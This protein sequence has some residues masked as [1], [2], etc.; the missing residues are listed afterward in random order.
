MSDI[1]SSLYY[2]YF[3][4]IVPCTI[5]TLLFWTGVRGFANP[6]ALADTFGLPNATKDEV[7][8]VQSSTGRNLAAALF[9]WALVYM[10]ERKALGV[11]LIC[12]TWAGIADTKLLIE[13]PRG[14]KALVHVRNIFVLAI[15]GPLLIR[16][17]T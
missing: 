3:L 12:W 4:D 15:L 5:G 14:E 7:V 2:S 8:F 11:F 16:S 17:S 6:Q 9:V 13:H 1:P 10:G